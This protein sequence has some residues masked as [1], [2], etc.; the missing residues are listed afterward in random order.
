MLLKRRWQE[1]IMLQSIATRTFCYLLDFILGATFLTLYLYFKGK[2]FHWDW[3][4]CKEYKHPWDMKELWFF[5]VNMHNVELLSTFFISEHEPSIG[6]QR[7]SEAEV[8]DQWSRAL[9]ALTKHPGLVPS[10]HMVAYNHLYLQLQWIWCPL[11]VSADIHV[12]YRNIYR[13]NPQ[14]H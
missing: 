10:T 5:S 14:T 7:K 1:N 12:A 11:L 4:Q 13:Q 6:Y 9:V 3:N 8:N 2:K